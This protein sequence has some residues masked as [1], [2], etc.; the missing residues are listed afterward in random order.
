MGH[1]KQL[2]EKEK[3]QIEA[4]SKT[5]ASIYRI[6]KEIGRSRDV[7]TKYL[8]NKDGYGTN[9]RTGRK[10]KL[11]PRQHRQIVSLASNSTKSCAK[12]AAELDV[13]VSRWTVHRAITQSNCLVS[14]KMKPKPSLT[15][16]HK[17]ARVEF[18]EQYSSWT[19][20]WQ[21][22]KG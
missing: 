11:S 1:G 15:Q 12:I 18:A 21:K 22:V 16:P 19:Q 4:H 7:I 10:P 5:G 6:S 17:D 13:K 8:Q 2:N 3:G 9:Y 20:E 14:A